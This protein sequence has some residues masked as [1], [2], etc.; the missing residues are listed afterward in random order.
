MAAA[1]LTLMAAAALVALAPVDADLHGGDHRRGRGYTTRVNT[2]FRIAFGDYELALNRTA[3]TYSLTETVTGTV[4]AT[5]L[6]VGWV[7]VQERESGSIQ[8]VEFA[9]CKLVSVAEKMGASGKRLLLGLDAPGG[10]PLDLYFICGPKEIQLTVE[11]TRDSKTHTLVQIGLL[12][13]LCHAET[14]G[15]L[16]LPFGEGVL[17]PPQAAS[18][19]VLGVWAHNGLLMPFIGATTSTSALALLTDSAYASAHITSL[20]DST[21]S[22]DWVYERDPERRRLDVRIIPLPHGD[23]ISIARAYRDKL[24]GE[25]NHLTLRK[26]LREKPA[27]QA[28]IGSVTTEIPEDA[29]E[30]GTLS[31]DVSR[32]E[33]LEQELQKAEGNKIAVTMAG[34]WAY[35]AADVLIPKAVPAV[36]VPV[37]LFSVVYRDSVLLPT[38]KATLSSLLRLKPVFL[39]LEKETPHLQL[40]AELHALTFPAF[41]TEHRFLTP[42]FLVEEAIYSDKTRVVINQSATDSYET[43]ELVLPPGGFYVKHARLEAHDALR[44]GAQAFSTRAWRLAR[45]LDGKALSASE[46]IERQELPPR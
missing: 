2:V 44:V 24:I 8:R 40:L 27:L 7:E 29:I 14:G 4:W 42:D 20:Q 28:Y 17:L 25:R 11:A 9:A 21:A 13:G 35:L 36:G 15:N 33:F 41:L 10:I 12:P 22:A 32:W 34:D 39:L 43:E 16:V 38:A 26:K 46:Q 19:S 31:P 1:A 30:L 45:S 23:Y 3:L 5:E 37:P 6:P 18:P